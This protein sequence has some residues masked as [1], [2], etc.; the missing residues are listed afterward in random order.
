MAK[1]LKVDLEQLSETITM[2]DKSY[3]DFESLIKTLSASVDALQNT[4]WKSA[5]SEA[6]FS[7]FDETWK[8]NMEMHLKII[9]HLKEC[10]VNAK[11]EY[12]AL[13][14]SI[15]SIGNTL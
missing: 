9:K 1:K 7:T 6:F 10:L 2:Y 3:N 13:Y 15:P 14:E 12:E 5:A 4:G 11:N 8:K